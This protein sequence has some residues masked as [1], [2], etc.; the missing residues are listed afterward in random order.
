MSSLRT[1]HYRFASNT[2]ANRSRQKTHAMSVHSIKFRITEWTAN[3][4][5]KLKKSVKKYQQ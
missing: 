3:Q 1:C 5:Q 4:K 2:K